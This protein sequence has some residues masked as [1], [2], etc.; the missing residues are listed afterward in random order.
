MTKLQC[1]PTS[2]GAAAVILASE[3]FVIEHDLQDHAVEF[4]AAALTGD[5]AN[6]FGDKSF[7]KLA[8]CKIFTPLIKE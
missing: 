2:D 5:S 4:L 3:K 6:T 1:C 7:R 8:G